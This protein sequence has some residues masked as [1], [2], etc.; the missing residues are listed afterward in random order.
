MIRKVTSRRK[1]SSISSALRSVL[2]KIET[3]KEKRKTDNGEMPV[4]SRLV[5]VSKTKPPTSI[6]EAYRC[7]QKHF[8]EN[9]VNELSE[10]SIDP[11]IQ[12]EC[13]DIRWHFIG[14]LQSNKAG[15]LVSCPNLFMVETVHSDKIANALNRQ[16]ESKNKEGKLKVMVQ[17]NTSNEDSKS[18][19]NTDE[20]VNIVKNIKEKCPNLEFAGLMT[21]G[22][23]DHDL[24]QGPNPDFLKLSEC[25]NKLCE[26]LKLNKQEVELSMGMS[27]DFEHAIELGST[28]VRVGSTIFGAREPPNK[29]SGNS[30]SS[31]EVNDSSGSTNKESNV[32]D[33]EVLK[34]SKELNQMSIAM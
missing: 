7:G 2:D 15:T 9:Y 5:A 28:N 8:G 24:S 27:A 16:W 29:T 18:G 10:K 21:I 17:V 32:K 33:K 19:C 1:M 26:E 22:S 34:A 31:S 25:R 11:E 13:K 14:R 12:S 3:A 4:T 23:F 6:V 30:A 20:V